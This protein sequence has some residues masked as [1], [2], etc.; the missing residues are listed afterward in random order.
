[1][2]YRDYL[3]NKLVLME[4]KAIPSL[5]DMDWEPFY[6]ISIFPEIERGKRLKKADQKP[7]DV[8]YASSTAI[9]NGI[10]G[11]IKASR[12][13][14]VFSNCIS[15]ANSGSVGSAFYE[16]FA[17]VASDHITH[18]KRPGFTEWHYL[19]LTCVIEKQSCNFNFNREINDAR[20]KKM[21]IML[22]TTSSG[23]PDWDYMEQYA[24]N[25]MKR[26]YD[27]YLAYLDGSVV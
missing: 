24:K 17:F 4:Y 7:G 3:M 15:L 12:G 13:T 20:I 10:D 19:F 27:Q 26:K 16:P 1:M 23:E 11:F 6:V 25:L 18:L 8:P 9:N 5:E 14:R 2:S 21:Q 22:P